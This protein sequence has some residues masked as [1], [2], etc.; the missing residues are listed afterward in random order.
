MDLRTAGSGVV[1]LLVFWA[2]QI[3]LLS[4]LGA[5]GWLLA[6]IIFVAVLWFIGQGMMPKPTA[7]QKELWM[8]TSIF[9]IVATF[10]ILYV[11]PYLGAVVPTTAAGMMDLGQILLSIWLIV[12][13]AAMFVTGWEMKWNVHMWIGLF[14]LI[15]ALHFVT[16]IN[17]GPN[18]YLHFG[19]V[20]GLPFVI[21]GLIRK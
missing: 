20:V 21:Y 19:L 10:I 11:G 3:G 12:F 16:S 2:Y 9:G 17:A 7:S 13:G 1:L 14:W 15:S 18:S 6:S 8:F 4:S 5:A